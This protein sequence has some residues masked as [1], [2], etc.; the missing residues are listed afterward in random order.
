MEFSSPLS[1]SARRLRLATLFC[2]A[3]VVIFGLFAALLAVSGSDLAEVRITGDPVSSATAAALFAAGLWR[4]IRMLRRIEAGETFTSGT[5]GD[6]RGFALFTLLAALASVFLPPLVSLAAAFPRE[7]GQVRITF[8][9]AGSDLL[10]ILASALL[11]F[12]TRL[13]REAQRIAEDN[14]QIV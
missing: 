2:T 14:S 13:L 12:V 4:L 5:I 6:L 8:D 9:L 1:R 7:A 11:F 10:A 3:L